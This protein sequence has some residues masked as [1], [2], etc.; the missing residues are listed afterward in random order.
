MAG[1]WCLWVMAHTDHMHFLKKLCHLVVIR[2]NKQVPF[3]II[4][5]QLSSL[6][7]FFLG[8]VFSQKFWTVINSKK[9]Y[10]L[11]SVIVICPDFFKNKSVTYHLLLILKN[12]NAY[13]TLVISNGV[14]RYHCNKQVSSKV[15]YNY[16]TM[17]IIMLMILVRTC[18]VSTFKEQI[19]TGGKCII[20]RLSFAQ[21]MCATVQQHQFA[22][23][24]LSMSGL[25]EY[26]QISFL[27]GCH[28]IHQTQ[29]RQ[30]HLNFAW[31][32][33]FRH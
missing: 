15:H 2:K 23:S 1:L 8:N 21:C 13:V 12:N 3:N 30:D 24:A 5:N 28:S 7:L 25:C 17:W 22:N 32:P 19:Y 31:L 20:V 4:I 18:W 33:E 6:S 26:Q 11:H 27:F 10:K 29:H 9:M 14:L 16:F